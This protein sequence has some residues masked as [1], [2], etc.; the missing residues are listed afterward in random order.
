MQGVS[1][2]EYEG[3]L[4]FYVNQP[5][6]KLSKAIRLKNTT[7]VAKLLDTLKNKFNFGRREL[8]K[9]DEGQEDLEKELELSVLIGDGEYTSFKAS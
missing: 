2:L 1:E 3:A 4:R 6:Q 9:Y 7:T 5:H 8:E